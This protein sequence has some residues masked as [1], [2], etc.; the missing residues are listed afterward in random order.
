MATLANSGRTLPNVGGDLNVWGSLNNALHIGADADLYVRPSD[1]DFAGY[2][3]HD[4]VVEDIAEQVH[5]AGNVSGA[6][7]LDY[8]NGHWQYATLTGNVTSLT[9]NNWPASG[10]GGWLT[11]ELVQD[12]TGSRTLTLGS[13]YDTPG[14]SGVTLSTAAG[15]RD[16]LYLR[17]RDGGTTVLVSVEK[18]FA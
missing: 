16:V 2:K 11:L 12:G 8:T 4:A 3:L 14:G 7:T 13:A 10:K 5:N 15:A 18:A 9:V 17:T 1:Y 6:V